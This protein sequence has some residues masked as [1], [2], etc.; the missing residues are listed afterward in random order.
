MAGDV[1]DEL[2]A[3][4][5]RGDLDALGGLM[6]RWQAAAIRH[7]RRC[8]GD[9]HIAEEVAQEGFL[10]LIPAAEGYQ[11]GGRFGPYLFRILTRLCID[12]L[13]R[14]KQH[15]RLAARVAGSPSEDSALEL[16]DPRASSPSRHLETHESAQR[17]RRELD[18]LPPDQKT[19][20]LLRELDARSY[21]EI[22]EILE[23]SL[24]NVKV[25]LHRGRQ[26][27]LSALRQSERTAPPAPTRPRSLPAEARLT[28]ELHA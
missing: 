2:M 18:L 11:A 26:K 16:A 27:L 5:A 1:D 15:R 17:I 24:D 14:R 7:A 25:L 21:A 23:C 8:L 13:R 22:A 10:R 28:K 6:D 9:F 19:A 4:L 20:L 3:R 12:E